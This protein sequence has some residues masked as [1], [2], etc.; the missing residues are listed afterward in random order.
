MGALNHCSFIILLTTLV[1]WYQVTSVLE[2][3]ALL[4]PL[5]ATAAG[6]AHHAFEP[7]SIPILNAPCSKKLDE[8][9]EHG[10]GLDHLR[11]NSRFLLVQLLRSTYSSNRLASKNI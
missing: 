1:Q 7:A 8:R 11:L 2:Q 6:P 9:N 5:Q 10:L 3:Y 4:Q